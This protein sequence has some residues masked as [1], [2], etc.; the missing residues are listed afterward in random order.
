MTIVLSFLLRCLKFVWLKI[1]DFRIFYQTFIFPGSRPL[2][3]PP[4]D[5]IST[6]RTS[7]MYQILALEWNWQCFDYVSKDG[8]IQPPSPLVFNWP[9]SLGLG[10][11]HNS[12]FHTLFWKL[13]C[14][15]PAPLIG[16]GRYFHKIWC[17][18]TGFWCTKPLSRNCQVGVFRPFLQ[19]SLALLTTFSLQA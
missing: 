15:I 13:K 9:K 4:E 7:S 10:I 19:R 18:I 12:E 8:L 14:T 2:W 17:K 6:S 1:V 3:Q 5:A 16:L 11:R